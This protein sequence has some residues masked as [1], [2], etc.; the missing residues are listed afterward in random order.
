[1]SAVAGSISASSISRRSLQTDYAAQS[2]IHRMVLT[3]SA[4]GFSAGS[5]ALLQA[6]PFDASKITCKTVIV[7]G[8]EDVFTPPDLVRSWANEIGD[9][10]GRDVILRDVGHWGAVEAPREVGELLEDWDAM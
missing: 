4:K 3:T 5:E 8:T 6:T 7:G 9:G 2:F 10:K 1:M